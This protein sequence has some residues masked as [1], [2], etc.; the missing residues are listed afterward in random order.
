MGDILGDGVDRGALAGV[1]AT[2]GRG[3]F[4]FHMG[5]WRVHHRLLRGRLTGATS[6][7][8]CEGTAVQRPIL[9]GLGNIDEYVIERASGRRQGAA[10]RLFDPAAQEWSIYWADDVTG[11]LVYGKLGDPAIGHFRDGRGEFYSYDP[12]D[13]KHIWC[14]IA[15]FEITATSCRWEQSFSVDGGRKWETNWIMEYI[16][17]QQ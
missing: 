1:Q 11:G 14:R 8:E 3:D 5:R 9:S 16:R 7:E 13:S 12:F 10:I 17:Q 6:W 2:D 4:D 15:W